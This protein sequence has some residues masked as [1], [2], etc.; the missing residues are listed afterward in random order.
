MAILFYLVIALLSLPCPAFSH[1]AFDVKDS[2]K[3][4]ESGDLDKAESLLHK[5]RL[6]ESDSYIVNYD[7]GIVSYRKRDYAKS[8]RFFARASELSKSPDQQF[9]AL[10]NMGNA[11][12]KSYDFAEAVNAYK[13]ALAIKKDDFKADYNLKVAEKK[14]QE[15][16][17]RQKKEQ[18]QEQQRDQQNQ[19]NQDQKDKQKQENKDSQNQKGNQDKN[20]QQQNQQQNQQQDQQQNQQQGQQNQQNQQ[21]QQGDSQQNSQDSESENQSGEQ[22]QQNA[23]NQEGEQGKENQDSASS[24]KKEDSSEEK[25]EQQAA[26]SDN[27]SD[28]QKDSQN[29][30]NK[31]QQASGQDNKESDE[32]KKEDYQALTNEEKAAP[33]SD[34]RDVKMAEDNGKVSRPE[35]S[36]RARAMKNIRLKKED[37]EAYLKQMEQRE[38]EYQQY[39]R[40]DNIEEKDPSTM[41]QE[42]LKE[43]LRVR[44]RKKQ[45]IQNNEQDW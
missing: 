28:E 4:L 41:N 5:A 23:Q 40:I 14:L 29:S 15:M 7:L 20:G 34:R 36:Q 32:K 2:L 39:Y 18:E 27:Q 24:E 13:N 10:Y 25:K 21:G 19:Q 12:F 16:L 33:E 37:V 44:N 35:A 42:E 3:A 30:E 43:W 31:E 22:Q 38:G 6:E 8:I 17:E 26:G 9:D 45:Q 1:P 11:A